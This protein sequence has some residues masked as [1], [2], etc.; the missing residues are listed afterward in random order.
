MTIRLT[1]EEMETHIYWN[2]EVDCTVTITTFNNKLKKKLRASAE[3][4]PEEIKVIREDAYGELVAEFP[5][6]LVS[7]NIKTPKKYKNTRKVSEEQKQAFV[8][9]VHGKKG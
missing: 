9:R 5:K 3:Q 8:E 7:F 6:S 1:R 4:F 2:E